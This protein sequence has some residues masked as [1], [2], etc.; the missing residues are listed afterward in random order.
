M[1]KRLGG[2]AQL[3]QELRCSEGSTR[4]YQRRGLITPAGQI[5]GRDVFDLDEAAKVRE[6][7]ARQAV[8]QG[9]EAAA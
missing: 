5:G 1:D 7:L 2:R 9:A 6:S 3:A 4:N 8:S